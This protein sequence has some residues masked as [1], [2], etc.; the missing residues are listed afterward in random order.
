MLYKAFRFSEMST[1]S[2]DGYKLLKVRTT[3]FVND[4]DVASLP[5]QINLFSPEKL[6]LEYK[7]LKIKVE[8]LPK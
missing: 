3:F 7:D 2:V 5:M 8:G 6:D 4:K 1:E